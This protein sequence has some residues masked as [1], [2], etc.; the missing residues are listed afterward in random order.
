MKRRY[1]LFALLILSSGLAHSQTLDELNKFRIAQ[2]LE[3]AG[4]Y[5]RAIDFYQDL[6]QISPGNIVYFDGLRRCYM[7]L[8]R[9]DEAVDLIKSR[10]AIEPSNVVLYGELGD[11]LYKAG[12]VDSAQ[13]V[14][15]DAISIN[16]TKPEVYRTIANFMV[17]SRLFDQ[18][19]DVLKKGES[20]TNS[21]IAFAP[22][23]ARLYALKTD[24]R[25]A[26]S[27]LLKLLRVQ[28]HSSALAYIES[29]IGMFSSSKDAM[30]QFT[31]E[32]EK[33]ADDSPND[34]D[35]K[36]LLAF[37]YMEVRDY[38]S[39][40]KVYKWLDMNS[41]ARGTELM[42]FANQAYNDEAY[43]VSASAYKEVASLTNQ[44]SVLPAALTG[45]ANSLRKIGES[46]NKNGDELCGSADSLSLL[47]ESVAAYIDVAKK[48]P[49]TDYAN[50]AIINAARIR[51]N[52]FD[53]IKG[54]RSLLGELSENLA[55]RFISEGNLLRLEIG[56]REGSYDSVIS[57]GGELLRS[58][59][60]SNQF[61]IDRVK[62]DIGLAL[63]YMGQVDSSAKVFTEISSNPMSDV[64]N[65][66][67]HYLGIIKDNSSAP[68]AL[69]EYARATGMV[70]S[71]RVPEGI[72]ILE[73]ILKK[74]PG[75]LVVDNAKLKLAEAYCQIGDL[76]NSIRVYTE[77]ASDSTGIFSDIAQ[78]RLGVIY[79]ERLKDSTKALEEFE[80]FL[81][82]FPASIYQ[83]KVRKRI[84]GLMNMKKE[85]AG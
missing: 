7:Q 49:G 73:D 81:R 67:L 3:G 25:N 62:L 12:K 38:S 8:K 53:D 29:Q 43:E 33:R 35:I 13:T 76:K 64:A 68:D 17:E 24:Y 1:L 44:K 55:Q 65:E 84:I 26:L 2:A 46:V 21:P 18:A 42:A 85:A 9:Y 77:L 47:A 15:R 72:L 70:Q 28:D 48:Y 32:L 80:D 75:A 11:A 74:F 5:A 37:V 66:A 45:Y 54:A 14:W 16:K 61:F 30:A 83:D 56:L 6:H 27:E 22:E 50:E 19:I 34:V 78:F 23:I 57:I 60:V 40:Y 69:R 36:R 39:A 20:T 82:R 31:A 41:Q 71:G 52:Y 10:I 51:M 4:E 58:P 63:F 79:Q 59:D